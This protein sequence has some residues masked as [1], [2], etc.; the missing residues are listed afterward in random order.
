MLVLCV[1][2]GSVVRDHVGNTV[3][4]SIDTQQA[5]DVMQVSC[6]DS[7]RSPT[8]SSYD[9]PSDSS[10]PLPTV[11]LSHLFCRRVLFLCCK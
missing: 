11:C 6:T 1:S 5:S 2:D 9:L 8:E 10:N 3:V 7:E 4:N